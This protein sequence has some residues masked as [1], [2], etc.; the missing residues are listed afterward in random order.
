MLP[1]GV[2]S[3]VICGIHFA[4]IG[5]PGVLGLKDQREVGTGMV[6]TWGD[7]MYEHSDEVIRTLRGRNRSTSDV[8]GIICAV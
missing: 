6:G 4:S 1:Y 5:F 8:I 7:I 3:V 2:Q